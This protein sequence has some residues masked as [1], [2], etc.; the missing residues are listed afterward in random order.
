MRALQMMLFMAV[1]QF[2]IQNY[3]PKNSDVFFFDNNVWVNIYGALS[4]YNVK[5][6]KIFS[7]FLKEIE[8]AGST[9]VTNSMI[10]SE[11]TNRFFRFYFEQ[12]KKSQNRYSA[13]YKKDFVVTWKF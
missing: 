6:Q 12:W 13:D 3:S 7:G 4:N 10:L 9:I 11:F 8:S 2:S 5:K 1:K